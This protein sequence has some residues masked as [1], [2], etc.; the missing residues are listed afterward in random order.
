M[1][2]LVSLIGAGIFLMLCGCSIF[3]DVETTKVYYYDLGEPLK[4]IK[5]CDF[6]ISINRI[7]TEGPFRERMVFRE[8]ANSICF[9]EYSRWSYLPADMVKNYFLTALERQ[10]AEKTIFP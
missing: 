10:A 2:N 6:N 8:S 5:D 1:K 9:D 7:R 4:E 3:P